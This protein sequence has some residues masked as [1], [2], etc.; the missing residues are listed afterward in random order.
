MPLDDLDKTGQGERAHSDRHRA[1]DY[2]GVVVG[3]GLIKASRADRGR[4][5]GTGFAI[6]NIS[7]PNSSCNIHN[8]NTKSHYNSNQDLNPETLQPMHP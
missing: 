3:L 6:I 5:F 8:T 4:L 1:Q 2:S 7:R